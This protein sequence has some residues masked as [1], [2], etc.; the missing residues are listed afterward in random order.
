MGLARSIREAR[1][2][3]VH[4]HIMVNGNVV[5]APGYL[6]KIDDKIEF[7]PTSPFVKRMKEEAEGGEAV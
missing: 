2:L 4:R 3:I 1:Q 6:V 5:N 7:K